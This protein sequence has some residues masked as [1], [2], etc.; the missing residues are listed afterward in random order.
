[1][2]MLEQYAGTYSFSSIHN[3]N[4]LF[5]INPGMYLRIKNSSRL[6]SN[7]KVGDIVIFTGFGTSYRTLH[8]NTLSG[9]KIIINFQANVKLKKEFFDIFVAVKQRTVQ[10]SRLSHGNWRKGEI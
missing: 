10:T 3:L 1:M 5:D 4:N 8:A 9:N 6:D 2:T 7:L